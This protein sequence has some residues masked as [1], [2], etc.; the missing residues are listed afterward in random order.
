MVTD[1][2]ALHPPKGSGE[3]GTTKDTLHRRK[4]ISSVNALS[5]V[6]FIQPLHLCCLHAECLYTVVV[7]AQVQ[8][9]C[10]AQLL[11]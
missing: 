10:P 9:C 5:E 3:R 6:G 11:Q 1:K 4:K 7:L 8:P 2:A